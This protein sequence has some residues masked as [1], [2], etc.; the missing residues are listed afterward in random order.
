MFR[1]FYL[2]LFSVVLLVSCKSS[3]KPLPIL[4]RA[5]ING[6]DTV[7]P[8]I[9]DFTFTDQD[10]NYVANSTFTDKVYITDFIFL[11]C[12]TI[13]P[14]MTMEMKKVYLSFASDNRVTFLSHTI[15]PERDSIP[16]LKLY[17]DALGVSSDRW[18]FVTGS[19][20]SIVHLAENSYYSSAYVDST[21]PG[22]FV[23]SGGLL[24]I[25]K[26]RHIR[27]VYSALKAKETERL[28]NDIKQLLLEQF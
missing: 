9:A 7:Y 20:D 19:Q 21:A 6:N 11:S 8:R 23:H 3:P 13:C 14:L 24:L 12:P 4:G 18:H 17:A 1:L 2:Y 5:T 15:D 16:R 28:I 22:G 26:D 10:S 25:D 27:G